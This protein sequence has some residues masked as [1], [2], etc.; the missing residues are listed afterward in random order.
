MP[1]NQSVGAI[2]SA[3]TQVRTLLDEPELR[4]KW[5][6]ALILQMLEDLWPE[7]WLDLYANADNPPLARYTFTP[8]ADQKYYYLPS[9]VGEILY[10]AHRDT[11]NRIIYELKPRSLYHPWGENISFEANQRLK[12]DLP[13]VST[14]DEIEV[15]Y[16]PS[17]AVHLHSST[18]LGSAFSL[19]GVTLDTSP[20]L[21]TYDR[22]PH[23][24]E[25]CVIRV[26][27]SSTG[28]KPSGYDVFPVME[29]IISSH[30]VLTS[31]V[32][33]E[34]DF[35][36]N[37]SL[38]SDAESTNITYEIYPVEATL[39]WP[40]LIKRT[41]MEIAAIENRVTKAGSLEK[42]YAMAKR[43]CSLHLANFQTRYPTSF[44]PRSLKNPDYIRT[45]E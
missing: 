44:D 25:G 3:I 45:I 9:T 27:A 42:L 36:V 40:T 33:V 17:G 34:P 28:S 10:I 6:D 37:L 30:D 7:L 22:R 35:D 8:V 23:S 43:A 15:L 16:I 4:A 11:N 29:R 24:F 38:L 13:V 12:L 31:T 20:T 14:S 39:I 5:T 32:T 2:S 41:A 21:G 18:V 1:S 19:T 26:L